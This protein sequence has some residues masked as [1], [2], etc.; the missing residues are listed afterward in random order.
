MMEFT[1]H[2]NAFE[3]TEFRLVDYHSG[4][5]EMTHLSKD[6]FACGL[7]KVKGKKEEKLNSQGIKMFENLHSREKTD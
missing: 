6:G 7:E 3:K 1:L 2:E 5:L 4:D